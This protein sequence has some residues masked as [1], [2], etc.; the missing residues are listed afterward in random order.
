MQY[1]GDDYLAALE[2]AKNYN[3]YIAS[4]IAKFL[5]NEDEKIIDFGAGTGML[6]R[7]VQAKTGK[8]IQCLE[9]AD[10]LQSFH[11]NGTLKSLQEVD[12]GAVDFIYSSNVLEHIQD[13]KAII[14]DMERVLRHGGRLVLYLPAFSYLFSAMDRK[15]GHYRRY[16]KRMIKALFDGGSW[17]IKKLRYVDCLGFPGTLWFKAF[18]PRGG[19]FRRTPL[20]FYDRAVFPLSRA[21]DIAT[22][23]ILFGKNILACAEKA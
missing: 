20:L 21:L 2:N 7:I 5:R 4:E 1:T 6:A 22:G 3:A 18:G 17:T 15:V 11:P 16:N 8:C 9:P 12:N 10:N 19:E 13:D 14:A 23:G